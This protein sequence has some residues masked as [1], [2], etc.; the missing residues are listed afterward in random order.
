MRIKVCTASL[1]ENNARLSIKKD[2]TVRINNENRNKSYENWSCY[3][4][5]F[6]F[7][8]YLRNCILKYLT[9]KCTWFPNPNQPI[10]QMNILS[11]NALKIC[12]ISAI[13]YKICQTSKPWLKKEVMISCLRWVIK[14]LFFIFIC[15]HWYLCK[16]NS[17]NN[18]YA[19]LFAFSFIIICD[20]ASLFKK[21]TLKIETFFEIWTGTNKELWG[22]MGVLKP[23]PQWFCFQISV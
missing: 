12:Q 9:N 7:L 23:L 17:E 2:K 18:H 3:F 13:W 1:N 21:I 16:E 11:A 4:H 14:A 8:S 20:S 10:F 19:N 22:P 15:L 5:H 6:L